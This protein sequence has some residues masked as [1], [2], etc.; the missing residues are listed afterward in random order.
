MALRGVESLS[1]KL[2]TAGIALARFIATACYVGRIPGAPGTYASAAAA[3]A[4]YGTFKLSGGIVPELLVSV[5]CLLSVVGTYAADSVAR[6]RNQEDPQEVVIDEIAGQLLTYAWVPVS[7]WTL[8]VGFFLFRAFDIWKPYPIRHVEHLP[9]GVG[10]IADD[11]LAGGFAC[12]A[13]HALLRAA[14]A[15]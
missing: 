4:F 12:L 11:L 8:L 15:S 3:I 5:V 14:S 2:S 9:K 7:P 6:A 13:L 10:V 1:P